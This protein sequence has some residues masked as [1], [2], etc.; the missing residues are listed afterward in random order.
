MPRSINPMVIEPVPPPSSTTYWPDVHAVSAA[1]PRP[2]ARD[3][4]ITEPTDLGERRYCRK[5]SSPSLERSV[6]CINRLLHR[7]SAR[8]SPQPSEIRINP[9]DRTAAADLNDKVARTQKAS[10]V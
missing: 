2:R 6:C 10:H 1:T 4:G 3:E 8:G 7:G 5:N 9:I